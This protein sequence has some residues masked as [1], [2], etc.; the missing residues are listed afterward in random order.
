MLY[1]LCLVWIRLQEFLSFKKSFPLSAYFGLF[2][3]CETRLLCVSANLFISLHTFAALSCSA[4]NKRPQLSIS[5]KD[6]FLKKSWFSDN[7]HPFKLILYVFRLLLNIFQQPLIGS[8]HSPE[9]VHIPAVR[10]CLLVVRPLQC[11]Q[12]F[13]FPWSMTRDVSEVVFVL[14]SIASPHISAQ[15][16]ARLALGQSHP[17]MLTIWPP[18]PLMHFGLKN[19][20]KKMLATLEL[21]FS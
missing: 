5:G 15:A 21:W 14:S 7:T 3:I 8:F 19:Q 10:V 12:L 13:L 1:I 17:C 4:N 6:P 20:R 2:L 9:L 16:L 18:E 11:V